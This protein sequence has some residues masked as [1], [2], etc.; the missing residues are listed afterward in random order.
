MDK[1]QA[2]A[3]PPPPPSWKRW[4]FAAF[5][6]IALVLLLSEHRAHILGWALHALVGACV[7][8][9]YFNTRAYES[10]GADTAPPRL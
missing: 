9:L 2:P 4:I 1:S 5:M 3:S 6:G 7:L 10:D 8:L